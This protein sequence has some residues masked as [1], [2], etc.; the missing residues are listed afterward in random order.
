M[1]EDYTFTGA[2]KRSDLGIRRSY[3]HLPYDRQRIVFERFIKHA[4]ACKKAGMETE[5]RFL[6]EIVTDVKAGLEELTA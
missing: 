5:P 1:A 6:A 4:L 3:N 2:L